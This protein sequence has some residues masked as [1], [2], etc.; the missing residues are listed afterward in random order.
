MEIKKIPLKCVILTIIMTA[1][2]V[3]ICLYFCRI[4]DAEWYVLSWAFIFSFF[5]HRIIIMQAKDIW[6]VYSVCNAL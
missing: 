4:A 5:F 2:D 6:I 3:N 1:T